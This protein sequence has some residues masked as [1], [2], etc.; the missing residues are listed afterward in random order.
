MN[1]YSPTQNK[2]QPSSFI[3]VNAGLLQRRSNSQSALTEVAPVVYEALR[4][5]G[6]S[7]DSNTKAF[8]ESRFRQDFSQVQVHTNDKAASSAEAVNAQAYTVGKNIVFQ[9]GA[10]TPNTV[11][12]I[13]LLA[14]EL[15]H[16][17]QQGSQRSIPSNLNISHSHDAAEI[18]ADQ[19]ANNIT[20]E[21]S[22]PP[23]IEA[24][25]QNGTLQRTPAAPMVGSTAAPLDRSKV[26]ISEIN[27]ILVTQVSG[28][29]FIVPQIVIVTFSEP[30]I[31]HLAW[32]LYNPQD[33]MLPGSFGT[34]PKTSTATVAP[35][36]INSQNFGKTINQGRY[37]LRCVGYKDGIPVAYADQSF[38]VWTSIPT[39]MQDLTTLNKTKASPGSKSLGE[40]G[41]AYARAMMLEHQNA[42]AATGTGKYMGNQVTTPAPS[43]VTK[44]D[45]TTYVLEVLK[46]A[47]TD[48]GRAADWKAVYDEAQKT[49]AGAFKGTELIKA[50][51]NKAGWK[52]VFWAPDPRNPQ[53]ISSEHPSAYKKVREKGTYYG[54]TVDA[55][56][57]VIDYR[58]T[59]ATKTENMTRLDQLRRVPLG[60]IAAR[61]G[62][63]M[64]LLLN[65]IV[66]EVHWDKP[67]TDPDVIEATQLEKW[68]WQSGVIVMP[69]EDFA[70]VF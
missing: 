10:F 25:T 7:L 23:L 16:V 59:S 50:L 35:F 4:S 45:C 3:P 55:G 49:S 17:V 28:L 29:P 1:Q 46:H 57:S 44:E 37:L 9:Q 58:P 5:P 40:V 65:G 18:E 21:G 67:A 2:N 60:V 14:H 47:F 70:A 42:V 53:D 26:K 63:H 48:K 41:A 68:I 24:T 19:I 69:P 31:N 30:T 43:G 54:I 8:M 20:R 52:A 61:G 64:T 34:V 6:Q 33:N 32:E 15:T 39:A 36:M 62:K 38:F 22:S 66:Y 56:K 27:D 13:K 51:E 12:G 11:S